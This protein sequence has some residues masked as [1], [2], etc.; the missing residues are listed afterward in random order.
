MTNAFIVSVGVLLAGCAAAP[1]DPLR[2]ANTYTSL[3]CSELAAE[4]RTIL[5]I[6]ASHAR[7]ASSQ[8]VKTALGFLGVLAGRADQAM[9]GQQFMEEADKDKKEQQASADELKKRS[10]LVERIIRARS[11][12]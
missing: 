4:Q 10:A 6:Q 3:S 11:C 1:I 7:A 2:P 5:N 12:S 8:G 9:Q